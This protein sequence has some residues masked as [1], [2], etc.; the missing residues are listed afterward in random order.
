VIGVYLDNQQPYATCVR[1]AGPGQAAQ[2]ALDQALAA[3]GMYDAGLIITGVIA[4]EHD[5]H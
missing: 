5:V 1:A 4:G 3:N 2:I